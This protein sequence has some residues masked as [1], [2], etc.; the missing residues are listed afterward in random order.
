LHASSADENLRN[1]FVENILISVVEMKWVVDNLVA[2][3][4]GV[5]PYFLRIIPAGEA[6]D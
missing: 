2:N 5:V 1:S 3:R 6:G 4:D